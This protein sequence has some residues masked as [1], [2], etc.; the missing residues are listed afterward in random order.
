MSNVSK[1]KTT[2]GAGPPPPNEAPGNT[3]KAPRDKSE[4]NEQRS[5]VAP[6]SVWEDFD[7]QAAREFGFKKG[8]KAK[9]FVKI[10]EHYQATKNS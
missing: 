9:F 1:L 5:M 3:A 7:A 8:S 6:P 10:F 4:G 2:K